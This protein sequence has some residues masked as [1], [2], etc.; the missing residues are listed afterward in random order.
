MSKACGGQGREGRQLVLVQDQL[1]QVA[2]VN[3]TSRK[4]HKPKVYQRDFYQVLKWK[5]SRE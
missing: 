3:E 1:G 4:R 5:V 2:E